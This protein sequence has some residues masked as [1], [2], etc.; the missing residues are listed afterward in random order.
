MHSVKANSNAQCKIPGEQNY[1]HEHRA[2]RKSRTETEQMTMQPINIRATLFVN[3]VK[4]TI[5]TL[6]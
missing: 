6:N 4:E 3:N 5:T 1:Q 2:N